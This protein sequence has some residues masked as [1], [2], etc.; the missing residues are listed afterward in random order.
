MIPNM[1]L[2]IGELSFLIDEWLFVIGDLWSVIG[3]WGH[4]LL[5]GDWLH[6]INEW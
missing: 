4:W 6:V 1:W 3:V 2:V 5:I